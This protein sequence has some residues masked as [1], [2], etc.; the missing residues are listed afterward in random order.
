MA[1]SGEMVDRGS[2]DD[3]NEVLAPAIAIAGSVVNDDDEAVEVVLVLTAIDVAE[4]ND[5]L[6]DP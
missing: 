3:N 6:E 4:V 2:A 1:E 5:I